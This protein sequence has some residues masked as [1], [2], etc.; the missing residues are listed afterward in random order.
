MAAAD[1]AAAI[2]DAPR[3]EKAEAEAPES[4][5]ERPRG[6]RPAPGCPRART[7][8]ARRWCWWPKEPEAS[9]KEGGEDEAAA[10]GRGGEMEREPP[11]LTPKGAACSPPVD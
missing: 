8:E 1:A 9:S 5:R 3:E 4:K 6:R 11:T 10:V 7:G 2:V